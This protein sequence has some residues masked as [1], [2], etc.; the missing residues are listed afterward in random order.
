MELV[1]GCRTDLRLYSVTMNQVTRYSE[2]MEMV[3]AETT[4]ERLGPVF[5]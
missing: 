1:A 4:A 2:K 3:E 5:K